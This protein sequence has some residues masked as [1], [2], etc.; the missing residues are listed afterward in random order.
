MKL[1][2][3]VSLLLTATDAAEPSTEVL[4]RGTVVDVENHLPIA[5]AQIHVEKN[6]GGTV[7]DTTTDSSGAFEVV[8]KEPGYYLAN[9]KADGYIYSHIFST[10]RVI[11]FESY[12]SKT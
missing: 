5:S 10:T 8:F 9:I 2:I 6:R 11:I 12:Q 1:I 3:L 7:L 4:F